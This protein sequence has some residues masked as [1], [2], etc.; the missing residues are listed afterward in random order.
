MK[1]ETLKIIVKMQA[2]EIT[3]HVVYGDLARRVRGPNAIILRRISE[4]EMKHAKIWS[5]Y[6][7]GLP[8]CPFYLRW[9]YNLLSFIFGVTFVINLME[10]S[11]CAAQEIYGSISGEVSEAARVYEQ[12]QGHERA[13][14]AMIDEERLRYISSMALGLNDALVEL[15]G[16]LAGFTFALGNSRLIA[17]AGLITGCAATLSMAASEYVSKKHDEMEKFPL[18]AAVYTG[19]TYM[20]AVAVLITPFFLI[21]TPPLAL[22]FSL[23]GVVVIVLMFTFFV[24]VVRRRPFRRAFL[25]MMSVCFG[26]ALISFFIG[27]AA[28][29]G[30]GID[31]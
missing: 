31:I 8:G 25:E 23:A 19:I 12:E 13:L 3:E 28:R 5:R 29:A 1:E 6:T 30:L 20:I 17:M 26:V 21:N 4:E 24:S 7:G 22:L 15:T 27:W 2:K 10:R 16:I 11:E 14:I 18:K 9:F